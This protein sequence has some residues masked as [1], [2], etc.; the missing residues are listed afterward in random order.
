MASTGNVMRLS[1]QEG[2]SLFLKHSGECRSVAAAAMATIKEVIKRHAKFKA[3][4]NK[5]KW[6]NKG[7][8]PMEQS[9]SK[10]HS[11]VGDSSKIEDGFEGDK[12]FCLFHL[13]HP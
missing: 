6:F 11:I 4:C 1:T 3:A 9:V 2:M 5:P 7:S 12:Q 8:G 13:V 10:A